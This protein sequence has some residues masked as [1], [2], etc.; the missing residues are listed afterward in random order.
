MSVDVAT[1]RPRAVE[2]RAESVWHKFGEFVA[3][4]GV[5]LDITAGHFMSL[6]GPSG[7]GKT[8]LLR[9][10]A[11]LLRPHAG[12][13]FING[14]NVTRLPADKRE[15]GFVFQNYALFPHLTVFENIAFPLRLRHLPG[16]EMRRR[17]GSA[18]EKVFLHGLDQRYPAELSGG[19]Q[20]R[21][22]L[23][24]AIVF[25]PTVLLMDEPL[26]SLDKRLRQQLQLE[27]RRLQREVGI[28][29][30]YVTHDQEEAFTMSDQIAVMGQGEL[31]QLGAP[32]YV[33]RYPSDAFVADFV[34]DLNYFEGKLAT[35]A[36]GHP[37]LRT[38]S[39]LTIRVDMKENATPG[40]VAGCGIRPELLRIRGE[41]AADNSYRAVVRTLTFRGTHYW[42][43]LLLPSGDALL[44]MLPNASGVGEGDDV[45]VGWDAAEVRIFPPRKQADPGTS[46]PSTTPRRQ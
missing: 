21:V 40:E 4:R 9:I 2:V 36:D 20:Q 5:S 3:L 33:Y 31:H 10:I 22:A 17:V 18:L 29:T 44:A 25:D 38:G 37:I 8:T 43:D 13:I 1:L 35:S 14:R 26:G 19:Q 46:G 39:G 32:E 7:S 30:V 41:M 16:E 11:G 42:A 6:L 12:Q 15:I 23:A 45:I 28:T 24:R 34:G 27:L